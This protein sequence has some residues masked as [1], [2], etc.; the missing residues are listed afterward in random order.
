MRIRCR[1]LLQHFLT[2]RSLSRS[3]PVWDGGKR[4]LVSG[5]SRTAHSG[6]FGE[7]GFGAIGTYSIAG[8]VNESSLKPYWTLQSTS[9]YRVMRMAEEIADAIA[10]AVARQGAKYFKPNVERTG[11]YE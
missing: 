10:S 4:G 1:G 2:T 3:T 5:E 7:R 6:P 9:L 8:V 11:T